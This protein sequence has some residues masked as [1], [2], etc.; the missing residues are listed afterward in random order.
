MT[1]KAPPEKAPKAVVY[2]LESITSTEATQVLR[3]AVPNATLTPD[4]A[5]PQKLTVFSTPG[6]QE[7]IAA[8][9]QEIDVEVPAKMVSQVK[10]YTVEGMTASSASIILRTEVPQARVSLGSDPQQLVVFARPADHDAVRQMIDEI[11]AAAEAEME[12]REAVVYTLDSL[13]PSTAMTFL[14]EVTPRAQLSLGSQPDQ[15]IGWASPEDHEAIRSMLDEIDVKGTEDTEVIVYTLD[16]MSATGAYYVTQFLTNAVPGARF[17]SGTQPGQLVAWA[18]PEEHEE[19]AELIEQLTAKAPPEKAP[20]AV[21]YNLQSITAAGANQVLAAAVPNATLTTDTTDL[22]KLT[23]LAVT[24]DHETIAGILAEIDVESPAETASSVKVYTVEGMTASAASIILRTQVP[25]ARVSLGSDLQQLVVFARPADHDAVRQVIDEI[26]AASTEA[27][28][29]RVAQVYTLDSLTATAAMAFLRQVVPQAQLSAGSQTDQLIAWARPA[30]H[31]KIKNTLAEIDIE[32]PDDATVAI[33]TL[34]GMDARGA[35]YVT[36]FLQTTVPGA[37]L[38]QGMDASQ[39]V[40]WARPKEHEEIRLLVEQLTAKV[41]PEKAPKAVVYNLKSITAAGANQVLAAAV[42]NATL[43]TD[44][45]NPQRLTALAVTADHETIAGILQEIDV[46]SPA[47]MAS[48]V[49]VYTIEGMTAATASIILRTQVPL[50]RVSLGTDPQQLVVFARPADHQQIKQ[51]VEGIA[52]AAAEGEAARVARVY[53]LDSLTATAAMAFLRQV[54]PQAELSAGSERDQLIAWARPADHEKIDATLTEIDVEGPDDATAVI[55]TL[56]KMDERSARFVS[57]F[58]QN[59]IPEARFV[60][61]L[62]LGQLVAWARPKDHEEIRNLVDQ[63]T[64]A[65]AADKAPKAVVYNLTSITAASASQVLADAVPDAT[66][67]TDPDDP[68]KITALAV[69]ADHETIAGVLKEIDVESPAETAAKVVVYPLVGMESRRS[70]Y[71]YRFIREAVPQ[72]NLTLSTD[73]TQLIAWA[74]PKDHERIAE[75]LDQVLHESPELARKTVVYTLKWMTAEKAVEVLT[76]VVREAELNVGDDPQKLIAF[77]RPA[78]QALIAGTLEEIDVEPSPETASK[79]VVYTLKSVTAAN[80][81][82]I[83]QDAMPDARFNV[84]ADPQRLIVWARP[85]DH[86]MIETILQEVDVVEP[87]ETA[88]RAILY[89]LEWIA[90]ATA[91]EVLEPAVPEASFTS[92]SESNQLIAWAKPADH[93]TIEQALEKIDV[94]GPPDSIVKVVAYPLVGLESR[95]AYYAMLFVRDAVPEATLTLNSDSTQLIAWARPKEHQ[96]IAEL[97]EQVLH[98]PP[99]LAHQ[100][101][102][103]TLKWSTADNATGILAEAVRGADLRA[104]DDPQQLIAWA[105]PAEHEVIQ[106]VL[107]VIDVEPSAETASKAV[108][109]T[110]KSIT[111]ANAQTVLEDAVPDARFNVGEE[112]PQRLTAWA[113]PADHTMIDTILQEIDVA[114]PDEMASRAILYTLEWLPATTAIEVLQS[115]V[116]EAS[117]TTASE[118]NQL[119]AWAKPADHETIEKTLEQVDVEGPP[120]RIADVALYPLEGMSARRAIYA[121]R[122]LIEAVPEAKLSLTSDATQVIAWARPKEH[123]ILERLVER[124]LEESAK[125]ASKAVVYN[126]KVATAAAAIQALGSAVPDANF[127]PGADENQLLAFARPGDHEKIAQILDELDREPSPETEPTAV[128]YTLKSASM[129][130]AMQVLRTT[131]PQA[132]LSMGAEPHQL[133]AWARPADHEIIEE[134]LEKMAEKGPSDLAA[135]VVV[136]TLAETDAQTAIRFLEAAVPE[137]EFS[138]GSDPRRVIAWAR[139][140][141]H[142]VIERAVTEMSEEES[143]ETA[144]RVVVYDLEAT[145]AAAAIAVLQA[146]VP[147]AQLGVG[148]D[149]GKLIVWARPED[150]EVI[151]AA[152]EQFEADSWLEGNRIISVYPIKGGDAQSLL[153]VLTPVLRDHAQF[154]VDA[155]RNSL[156]VWADAKQHEMVTKTIEQFMEGLEGAEAMSSQVYRLNLADP[157]AALSVLQTLVPDARL[158]LDENTQSIV[159]S[160]LADDHAKIKATL[161][162]MDREGAEGQRPVLRMH[163]IATGSIANVY[164]ALA[165][166]FRQDP[167]VQLSVDSASDAII[168]I[169]APLKHGKIEELIQEIEKGVLLEAD[170]TLVL[171]PMKNVDSVSA[172]E[173]LERMMEKRGAKADISMDSRTNQLVAIARPDHHELIRETLD[174]LRA[175]EP[176]LEIYDLE[177]VD[178]FSAEM[179][180]LSEFA[181]EGLNAPQ[182]DLDPITQ[183]LFVRASEEQHQRIRDLLIKM[184]ESKLTLLGDRGT[185]AMRVIP[186]HG[187]LES[188]IEE[189]QRVWP[190]LRDNPIRIVTPS[191]GLPGSAEPEETKPAEAP[192]AKPE[193]EAPPAEPKPEPAAKPEEMKPAETPPAKPEPKPETPPAEPK[194]EPATK[195]EETRPAETPPPKPEPKPET[196]PA[197]PKPEPAAKVEETKPAETPPTKPEPKPEPKPETPPAEP[198]PEPAA[199][200]EETKPAE[201]PPAKPEPKPETPPAEAKPEP[202]AEPKETKPAETEA[203]AEGEEKDTPAE[204]SPPAADNSDAPSSADSAWDDAWHAFAQIELGS[205]TAAD[206]AQGQPAPADAPPQEQPKPD[207]Q[208]PAGEKAESKPDENGLPPV[209]VVPGEGTVTIV[210][211]DPE[212]L[213][214]FEE[215]LRT[216]L[217]S[218]GRIGRNISIF[219]LKHTSAAVAAEKLEEL[220][221]STSPFSWRRSGGSVVI[222]PDERL[223]TVL[224][225]GSRVDR[226]T[227]ESLLRILDSDEVPATLAAHKPN[228][229]AIKNVDAEQIAEVVRNVFKSQLT[230]PTSTSRNRS[231]RTST[232]SVRMAPQVAVDEGTNSLVVM[233]PSPL[234]EEIAELANT[235]DEAAGKDPARRVKIIPLEKAD[236]DRVQRALEQIFSNPSSGRRR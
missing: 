235:L 120:D 216:L 27:E 72:A 192:P 15:L 195:P 94:E 102:V 17:V 222:V 20:K 74:R 131:V 170:T 158:A 191:T 226:E 176:D 161:D 70:Y 194:P 1:A 75:L 55:Y 58:L 167:T 78:E 97:V 8:I 142:E 204:S 138:M 202:A 79:A 39:V 87:A 83:L 200:P 63:L 186:F 227:A 101:V 2:S 61:G 92:A 123:E 64:A 112:D 114:E 22:Q 215:L 157:S 59:A 218:T 66:L 132:S 224:V 48:S 172:M 122:F 128:A 165:L 31:E 232:A 228:L 19:I 30:D 54:V 197:E 137:A 47:E 107:E 180:I 121:L 230:P 124:L 134:I 148:S 210:S 135:K 16:N 231:G 179:A 5:N 14:R 141:D 89:T 206:Q 42:P 69:A 77:A 108:V 140:A 24:A 173:I 198:K 211:D 223:N 220:L 163:R 33:Y 43:T 143:P 183:Q 221:E 34:E 3:A 85:A 174:T 106:G 225:Q 93:E 177:Y 80:A 23:A 25:Q 73:S 35:F 219:E 152:V 21:V 129:T 156:I 10:V 154:V 40:A 166:L 111:A 205:P 168:A 117:F 190:T 104:G 7:T 28:A 67:A 38:V 88:S 130:E 46:E 65:P 57:I 201:T 71:A 53:T 189:I 119:I 145:G 100:M 169:A 52:A 125:L 50:A 139:P 182:V 82:G 56:E 178:P 207:E 62:E 171:Y 149:P 109:Y 155:E 9:L 181:D 68:H 209:Y 153:S 229:I 196:P 199:E 136:Y 116:P 185:E 99:E 203:K 81:Q 233:A 118:S 84:G 96:R 212:A 49:E 91:I 13:T 45:T 76:S 90:A 11:A 60:P 12:A 110:L 115:A 44:T 151:E 234:K 147:E 127:S 236:P 37:R 29:A 146:A 18:E 193:P 150:H 95:R 217:P 126:L 162:E 188:A 159:V 184:G 51:V 105:R 4:A 6:D 133:I 144:P 41:P 26:A 175:D 164:R 98:E 160:A 113:R 213:D 86:E 187:D 208:P 36:R 32:G 214:R 103:Y